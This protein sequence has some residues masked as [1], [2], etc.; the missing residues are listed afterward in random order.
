MPHEDEPTPAPHNDRTSRWGFATRAIHAGQPPD[1]ATGAIITPIYQTSTYVQ[2]GIGR[3]KGYEY[4]RVSNPT[5][6]ALETNVAS[7]EEAPHGHAFASG[8]SAID[9]VLRFLSPGD[10]VVAGNNLYGGST[11]LFRQVLERTGLAFSFVD[12][13]S[14]AA[15]ERVLRR[16]TRVLFIETPTNPMMVVSDIAALA[17]LARDRGLLLVVDNTFLSP[18][19]QRPIA[20][21]A[22]VVVHSST[23][24]LG[25][26]SD[27]I[28]GFVATTRPDLAEHLAF[29]QKAVGAVPSPLDSWLVLRG[30]KTLAVRMRQHEENAR[31]VASF[32]AGHRAV[33]KV[34][35]P[36][37]PGHPGHELSKRQA[38]GFGAM[39]SFVVESRARADGIL[40][41]LRVFSLAESLGGVESLVCHPATMTHAS[42]PE[43]E[44]ERIGI[45]DGMIRLSVGIEEKEDL[46]AD[47]AGALG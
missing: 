11:R 43:E 16:E 13:S 24:Y 7:L 35:Y 32:L 34:Y 45:V 44:R 38:S 20:L 46:L 33:C 26:H 40:G 10:H 2:E 23:K 47:L 14:M 6:T 3:H 9:A 15:V 8:L 41:R 29:M 17:R 28:G 21:G 12:T 18:Y 5:R 19:F 22:E 4:S 37:L 42:V 1:P 39:I 36:G 31:A 27:V 30:T 25:G